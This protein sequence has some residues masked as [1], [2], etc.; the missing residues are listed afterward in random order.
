MIVRMPLRAS[1][2]AVLALATWVVATPPLTGQEEPKGAASGSFASQGISFEVVD[3]YAFPAEGFMGD[4]PIV[5]VAVS[6][7]GFNEEFIS[8][9]RDRRHLLDNF[10]KDDETG[11]VYFEF[12]PSGQYQGLS[13]YLESG[14]GC[15]YCSGGVESTV[16]KV[17]GRLV[18]KLAMNDAEDQRSFTIDLD[19]PIESDD[20]G[21]AQGSGG[22]EPGKVYLA[23]HEA[24]RAGDVAAFRSVAG[25]GQVDNLAKAELANEVT[26]YF[27]WLRKDHPDALKVT[28]AFVRGERAL[29]LIAAES[30]IG[31]IEGEAI[32]V[33]VDGAWRVDDEMMQH[34]FE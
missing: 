22:G 5:A 30:P 33:R 18:G 14:N 23:Y 7:S 24:L 34:K 21:S 26:D 16:R 32:L 25:S 2:L 6:N 19:V 15:G 8:R 17:D 9:Y 28:D 20:F 27:N 4:E 13:F 1:P 10:F 11:L 29:V 3:A 31:K 12:S